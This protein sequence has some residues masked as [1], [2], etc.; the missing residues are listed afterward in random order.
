MADGFVDPAVLDKV[1]VGKGYI[2][3]KYG[4]RNH[5]YP[6]ILS[7]EIEEEQQQKLEIAKRKEAEILAKLK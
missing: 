7:E 5:W 1:K 3:A 2:A 4:F 6:A